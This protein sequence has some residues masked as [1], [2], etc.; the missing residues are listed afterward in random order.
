MIAYP[1]IKAK[2]VWKIIEKDSLNDE[3]LFDTENIIQQIDS[4]C[5]EWRS[6]FGKE[7]SLS[8]SSFQPVISKLKKN[9]N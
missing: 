7:Q 8:W 9:L 5:I 3:P 4:D 1:E 2:D 6:R